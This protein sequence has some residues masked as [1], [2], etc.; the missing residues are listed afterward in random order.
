MT[1]VAKVRV[2]QL[3]VDLGLYESKTRAQAALMAGIIFLGQQRIDKAGTLVP[4]D[5]QLEVKGS[6]C[7]YVSRG[8]LKLARAL[9]VFQVSPAGKKILDLGSSTGGFCDCLLQNG[10]QSVIA[11][12]VGKG[13][14]HQKLR[15][16]PR[17]VVRDECNARYLNP[18]DIGPVDWITADLSFISLRLIFPVVEQFLQTSQGLALMLIKPQFE[19]GAKHLRKGVVKESKIHHRVL[20]DIAQAAQLSGLQLCD[21]THSPVKGPAGNIEFLGHFQLKGHQPSPNLEQIVGAAHQQLNKSDPT[22]C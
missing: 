7:P 5:S 21:C 9:E 19:A 14:L 16:D 11:V 4:V 3:L 1:K 8:G 17:V 2:D 12:D 22:A 18:A 13:Q 10:A 15:L 20:E 6:D